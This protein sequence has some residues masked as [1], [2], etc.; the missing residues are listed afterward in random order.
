MSWLK[1]EISKV[2]DTL[3]NQASMFN[4][5]YKTAWEKYMHPIITNQFTYEEVEK[6]INDKITKGREV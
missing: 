5:N 4:C 3:V 6:Y 1:F 2:A